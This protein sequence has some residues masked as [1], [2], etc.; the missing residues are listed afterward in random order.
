[1]TTTGSTKA[2]TDLNSYG[3]TLFYYAGNGKLQLK[4]KKT[5]Q[6]NFEAAQL[7][8]G[9]T[10]LIC[11][12]R[13]FHK[14]FLTDFQ[15]KKFT[16]TT[17]SGYSLIT[18]GL[19]FEKNYLGDFPKG[20]GSYTTL[21]CNQLDISLKKEHPQLEK[22]I[23]GLT[24]F[25]FLGIQP[26]SDQTGS[27]L[28]LPL[29]LL[30]N[31][32]KMALLI[33]PVQNYSKVTLRVSTL[34]DIDVTCEVELNS[35]FVRSLSKAQAIVSD[36]CLLLSLA[37]GTQINWIYY[38]AF[39]RAGELQ[40]VS[41]HSRITKPYTPLPIIDHR[42]KNDIK[43]FVESCYPKYKAIEKSYSL[44]KLIIHYIDAKSESDYIELRALKMVLI[45]E[46]L[47]HNLKDH[48]PLDKKPM[49]RA[50]FDKLKDFIKENLNELQLPIDVQK[51]IYENCSGLNRRPFRHFIQQLCNHIKVSFDIRQFVKS[52]NQL[53]HN[54][55]FYCDSIAETGKPA[56][57]T[58]KW[59]EYTFLINCMDRVFLR[60]LDYQ[61]FYINCHNRFKREQLEPCSPKNIVA[62]QPN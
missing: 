41:H 57:S 17:D 28:A 47:R 8:D 14:D 11:H 16:G 52:R 56:K 59:K 42:Q 30:K 54:G 13:K 22:Y 39:N 60:L 40:K 24:N 20:E 1:M 34:K 43:H 33:R 50:H 5:I 23:F 10:L 31:Q 46:V 3:H 35:P 58:D 7:R 6:C 19:I 15:P 18:K 21:N 9:T 26:Y 27:F 45:M 32:Q 38:K 55:R 53:V 2:Q 44:P 48:L 29:N 25:R 49:R 61:G 12:T 37:Q 4:N 51:A 36:L 62:Q